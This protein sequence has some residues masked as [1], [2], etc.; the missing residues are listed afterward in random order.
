[1]ITEDAVDALLTA[2]GIRY[3]TTYSGEDKNALSGSST[4]DAWA[5]TF[6]AGKLSETFDYF[7]GTGHRKRVYGYAGQIW[8]KNKKQYYTE[9]VMA[10]RAAGVLHCLIMDS[11]ACGQSFDD[12]CSDYGYD[13][14]SRKALETYLTCQSNHQK[15]RRVIGPAL[16]QF[17]TLLEDY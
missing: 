9:K 11:S 3:T 13:T 12:W 1:M 8:D 4:M 2:N 16:S 5:I 17:T 10:P 7:T 6:T 15:L 14:D